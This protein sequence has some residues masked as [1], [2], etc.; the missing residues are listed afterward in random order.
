MDHNLLLCF[1]VA[2]AVLGPSTLV[3]AANHFQKNG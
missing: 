2:M 3:T 1:H